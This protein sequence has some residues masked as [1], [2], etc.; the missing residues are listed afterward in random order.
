MNRRL[1]VVVMAGVLVLALGSAGYAAFRV[2]Q[3]SSDVG[4]VIG[5][6][7][8][9]ETIDEPV[10]EEGMPVPGPGSEGIEEAEV[11]SE[12]PVP[13]LDGVEEMIV[14]GD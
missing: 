6:C 10:A 1:M 5:G 11:I 8:T 12:M 4:D 13:G 3:L 14:T 2:D 7:P 9:G